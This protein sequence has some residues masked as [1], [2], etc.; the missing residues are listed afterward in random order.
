M[1]PH[2][3]RIILPG[4]AG[5]RLFP[6]TLAISEQLLPVCNKSTIHYPLSISAWAA[7]ARF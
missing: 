6:L 3:N 2:M 7:S 5:T 4:G 1:E